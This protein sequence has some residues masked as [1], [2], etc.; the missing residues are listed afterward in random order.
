[1]RQMRWSWDE[2]QRTPMYVRRYCVDFLSMVNENEERQMERD[3]RKAERESR[4]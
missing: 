3:R 4:G 1:M 2:L